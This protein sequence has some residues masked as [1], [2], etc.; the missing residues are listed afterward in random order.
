MN[1]NV[2]SVRVYDTTLDKIQQLC[3]L[4]KE[5]EKKYKKPALTKGEIV[6]EAID[7]YYA[8]KLDKDTGADYLTRMNLMIQDALKQQNN[9]RDMTL[10]NI[11]RY[12]M[13]SYE[14]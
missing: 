12:A 2:L 8:M 7:A 13:M 6:A 3:Y 1:K 11:L 10:N 9:Q 14:A 4:E 5:M